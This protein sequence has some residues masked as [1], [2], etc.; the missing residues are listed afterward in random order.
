MLEWKNDSS[1]SDAYAFSVEMDDHYIGNSD[2]SVDV[3]LHA[4]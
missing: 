3:D 4:R 1:T 2:L